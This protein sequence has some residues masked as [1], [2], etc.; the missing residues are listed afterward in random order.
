MDVRT[1][2]NDYYGSITLLRPLVQQGYRQR[3]EV[4]VKWCEEN[5]IQLEQIN[6]KVTQAF[7]AHLKNTHKPN[8]ASKTELS[9][10][11][12]MGYVRNIQF[13]LNWCLGEETY[14][15]ILSPRVVN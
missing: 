13:W 6:D 1:A 10:F 9:S 14:D 12:L 15:S 3:L 2:L 8:K 7:V 11:T 4:F 5:D